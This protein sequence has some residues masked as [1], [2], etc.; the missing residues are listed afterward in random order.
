MSIKEFKCEN[1]HELGQS[2]SILDC[3]HV[4]CTF[5]LQN[6]S[7]ELSSE[8][9]GKCNKKNSKRRTEMKQEKNFLHSK[10]DILASVME[11]F[12]IR[13]PRI[14]CFLCIQQQEYDPEY[15]CFDTE[16]YFCGPHFERHNLNKDCVYLSK[17]EILNENFAILQSRREDEP[18]CS[19]HPHRYAQYIC[20]VDNKFICSRCE[21]EHEDHELINVTTALDMTR[22][23]LE[24]ENTSIED[25]KNELK[26]RSQY[27]QDK[28]AWEKQQYEERE[29]AVQKHYTEQ[30]K[31]LEK[32][33]DK[34]L[35]KMTAIFKENSN[36]LE[37]EKQ[38]NENSLQ[39]MY[40]FENI[41]KLCTQILSSSEQIVHKK[42]IQKLLRN[43]HNKSEPPPKL[44]PPEKKK[45]SSEPV[46]H[47]NEEP[48]PKPQ[49]RSLRKH[50]YTSSI[51]TSILSCPNEAAMI[52]D[53]TFDKNNN[54]YVADCTNKSILMYNSNGTFI[55]QYL[56]RK[57]T[58][59]A[60]CIS[61]PNIC[62]FSERIIFTT[63]APNKAFELNLRD[64]AASELVER[65][66]FVQGRSFIKPLGMATSADKKLL[67]IC[68]QSDDQV[69]IMNERLKK[70]SNIPDIPGP[71]GIAVA[72]NANI[73]VL[74]STSKIFVIT[75]RRVMHTIEFGM[76]IE[77]IATDSLN[78]II[79]SETNR[80]CLLV[81][82]E[83]GDRLK[84]F[85]GCG[86]EET[87]N[88]PVGIAV[89]GAGRLVVAE[90]N[91]RQVKVFSKI[92]F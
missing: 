22:K 31:Q 78:R 92:P 40:R 11:D 35:A 16:Q 24:F 12:K 8:P 58:T 61:I 89:D 75:N 74:S 13:N 2:S 46:S 15:F 25:C 65:F 26:Q 30:I 67:Y 90:M 42:S 54:I 71:V 29:M 14:K 79:I 88:F 77:Y 82:N 91:S 47:E 39:T 3:G 76:Q 83:K 37:G 56:L 41:S 45:I 36:R 10:V 87:I 51:N 6:I 5:C 64:G 62:H 33:R 69:H 48:S 43:A 81:H 32:T 73:Y 57:Y 86:V 85:A 53:V 7:F 1:C 17:E 66:L 34:E 44:S 49:K 80:H 20:S 52:S 70:E 38:N 27:L 21:R 63:S 28:C 84:T 18:K 60:Q 72:P 55:K 9:C 19:E 4:M 23:A 50:A 59:I 68:D